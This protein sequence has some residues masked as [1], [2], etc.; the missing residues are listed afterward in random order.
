M[1]IPYAEVIGDPI[2]HSK[3]PLIHRFWL[4]KLG[5]ACDYRTARVP[6]AGLAGHLDAHRDD[7]DWR[8]CNVT[9]PHKERVLP[10]LDALAPEA[11]EIGAANL[12]VRAGPHLVGYNSDVAALREAILGVAE[13][14]ALLASAVVVIG[15]GGASRAVLQV[16]RDIPQLEVWILNRDVARAA[17]LLRDFGLAGR[18]APPDAR[19]PRAGLIVNASCFGMAGFPELPLDPSDAG[20]PFVVDLVYAPVETG[21][22]RRAKEQGMAMTDGLSILIGQARVAFQQLFRRTAPVG[23]D[24]ALRGLLTR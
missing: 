8:G 22:L 3:S 20:K 15:A 23:C 5:M 12:V 17:T 11:E 9:L 6:A 10:L 14:A 18:A 1:G 19:L 2:A 16:L 13:E 21:L 24:E 4:E 7:P